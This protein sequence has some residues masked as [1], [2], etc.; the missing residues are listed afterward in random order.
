MKRLSEFGQGRWNAE[1]IDMSQLVG[2]EI[3]IMDIHWLNGEKG[4]YASI[5]ITVDGETGFVNTGAKVVCDMLRKAQES[6]ALPVQAKF[7][8]AVSKTG[9]RYLTVE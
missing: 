7:V 1:K 6:N 5:L 8:E 2:K 9:R 4:E 3:S